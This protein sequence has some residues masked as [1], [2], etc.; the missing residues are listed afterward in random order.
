MSNINPQ[1]AWAFARLLG[2]L[3]VIVAAWL[4]IDVDADLA[5]NVILAAIALGALVYLWWWKNAPVTEAAQKAQEFFL[6][7]KREQAEER[8]REKELAAE[9]AEEEAEEKETG[10]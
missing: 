4:G 8:E 3:V 6:A 5:E 1:T 7:L 9:A 10:R 2:G